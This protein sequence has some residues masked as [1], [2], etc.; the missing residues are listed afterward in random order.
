LVRLRIF[1]RPPSVKGDGRDEFLGIYSSKRGIVGPVGG[2]NK[3][4]DDG[5][6]GSLRIE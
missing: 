4:D 2:F 5:I 6:A 3:L 1:R